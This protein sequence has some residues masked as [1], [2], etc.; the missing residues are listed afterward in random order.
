MG[1]LDSLFHL[2]NFFA[3]ALCVGLVAAW[4]AKL[5]WRRE[6]A[7]VSPWRMAA[8]AVLASS[9]VLIGGL[10]VTGHDGRMSTYGAM[11]LACA[12]AL[13]WAGWLKRG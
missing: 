3:P 7:Q 6:L 11:V 13:W 2:S 8:S 4:L 10:L 1:V 12:L 5:L 9:L